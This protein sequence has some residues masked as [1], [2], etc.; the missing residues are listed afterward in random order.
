MNNY[1]NINN[2]AEQA[3]LF[4]YYCALCG[5][6]VLITNKS[7]EKLPLRSTDNSIAIN[8]NEIYVKLY[9]K[10]GGIVYIKR[11]NGTP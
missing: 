10:K 6:L 2:S 5:A 7:L 1:T 11:K 9:L 3:D 4:T 8:V